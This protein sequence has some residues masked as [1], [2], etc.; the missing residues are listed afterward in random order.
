MAKVNEKLT[1]QVL[2]VSNRSSCMKKTLSILLYPALMLWAGIA[3]AQVPDSIL[4]KQAIQNQVDTTI[5]EITPT[6]ANPIDTAEVEEKK[7]GFVRRLFSKDDYPNPK[8]ALY[9]SLAIP[10]AGQIYNKRYWKAPIVYGGY[11]WLIYAVQFNTRNYRDLRDAYIAELNDE[12]HKFSG[13][14]YDANDLRQLRD[15]YDKNKQLSYIGI[16]AL[17][18]VQTAEAFVDCHLKTFDVSD[19]LS[20]Q[21]GPSFQSTLGGA[22]ASGIGI[23][24]TIK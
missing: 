8:K 15:Q 18:L 17:H 22:P 24:L 11:A 9:L 14:G 13:L 20:L 7:L 4:A 10:G 12:T 1:L 23:S 19:D 5:V 21:V 6:T 3:T 16:F 2:D